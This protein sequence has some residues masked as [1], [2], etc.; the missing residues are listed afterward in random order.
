MRRSEAKQRTEEQIARA[1]AELFA[2][3][4]VARTTVEQI[5]QLAGV[6]ERTFFRYFP[7][8]EDAV[9]SYIWLR[10]DEVR[11]ALRDRPAHES[12]ADAFLAAV[13]A[14]TSLDHEAVERDRAM[15]RLLRDTPTL[16][17]R[18]LVAGWE[19]AA[20]FVPLVADRLELDPSS[21]LARVS[22][23]ALFVAVQTALEAE[24]DGSYTFE[25]ALESAV[26]MLE[27]GAGLGFRPT[28][29][30]EGS[31]RSG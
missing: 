26:R 7:T 12:L 25:V 23:N 3:Q 14:T 29:G 18:W 22:T 13:R 28:T 24:A 21:L 9:L 16:R 8:K 15:L 2:V 27:S 4:G 30:Q 17:A 20:S 19:T 6:S 11:A 31:P 5:A 1:A 10:A